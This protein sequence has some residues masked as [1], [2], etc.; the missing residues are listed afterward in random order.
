MQGCR[1]AVHGS[2]FVKVAHLVTLY[3]KEDPSE[4]KKKEKHFRIC[5][6]F[7]AL[8]AHRRVPE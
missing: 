3:P 7:L 5:A 8:H 4:K 1:S 2:S 6:C